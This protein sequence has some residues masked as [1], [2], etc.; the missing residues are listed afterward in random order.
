VQVL[1]VR[2]VEIETEGCCSLY[3]AIGNQGGPEHCSTVVLAD[4]RTFLLFLAIKV[5]FVK[6]KAYSYSYSHSGLDLN[7]GH[8]LN[9]ASKY[10]VIYIYIYIY[11]YYI[12]G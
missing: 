2:A 6:L 3:I 1:L 10:C 11:I 9:K 12:K 5:S 7:M 4:Y 8:N